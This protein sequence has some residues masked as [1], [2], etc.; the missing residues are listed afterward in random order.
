MNAPTFEKDA[1][2]LHSEAREVD[3]CLY[4]YRLLLKE[5]PTTTRY[6]AE[7][8]FQDAQGYSD[9]RTGTLPVVHQ[10]TA[11]RLFLYLVK[12]LVTPINLPYVLEDC[13]TF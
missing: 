6:I 13:L 9:C 11:M 12:H 8:F 2:L 3:G 1:I 7:I 10:K 5:L 4:R